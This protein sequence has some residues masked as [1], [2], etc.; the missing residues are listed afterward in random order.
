MEE[1]P[2]GV[3]EQWGQV[4][5]AVGMGRGLRSSTPNPNQHGA[6]NLRCSPCFTQP[7]TKG[8]RCCNHHSCSGGDQKEMGEGSLAGIG[9]T[10]R[11]EGARYYEQGRDGPRG[12]HT[13]H[14]ECAAPFAQRPTHISPAK[15][16][17]VG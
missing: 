1:V 11:L 4:T 12:W 2:T 16:E 14:G 3:C 8:T 7:S 10:G 6:V 9:P 15:S 13:W 17:R 5:G